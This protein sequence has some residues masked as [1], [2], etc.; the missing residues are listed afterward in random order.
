MQ[1]TVFLT[2]T[3]LLICGLLM[4]CTANMTQFGEPPRE[5]A[6][7]I[8]VSQLLENLDD[9]AGE[10]V[11][12]RGVVTEM[13]THS[14]CW[15][16]V[17]DRQGADGVFVKF[18]YDTSKGRVPAEAIGQKAVVEGK[19]VVMEVSEERRRHYAEDQGASEA[20]LAKIIGPEKVAQLEC[21]S[22]RIANVD[23]AQPKACEHE[24]S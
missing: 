9:Y 3:T 23:V 20:E 1:R 14:G 12:V 5:A 11:R 24:A 18:T 2:G 22:A 19:V 7:T 4:G 17:A 8:S 15:M 13:C 21:P 6:K 16:E 10:Y